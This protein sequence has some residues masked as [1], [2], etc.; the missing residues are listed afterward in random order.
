MRLIDA[1][2]LEP[3]ADYDDGEFW[4]VSIG[5]IQDAPTIEP[6]QETGEWIEDED[7]MRVICSKCG[8]PNYSISDFC[9]NCGADMRGAERREDEQSEQ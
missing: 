3:D 2:L 8:E 6:K 4:A 5:Q 1:D 9:P 7:E